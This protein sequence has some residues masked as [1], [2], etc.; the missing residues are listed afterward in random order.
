MLIKCCEALIDHLYFIFKAVCKF[1]MYHPRWLESIIIILH[2]I[3]KTSYNV[4]KSYH[5]IGLI[6]TIPKLFLTL[7]SKHISFL[8]EKH[9]LLLLSQFG[10][11]PGRNMADVMLLVT[12]KIKEAWRKGKV[13]AMLFLDIQG[14]FPNILKDQ[15]IHNMHM[16]QVPNCFINI[17]TTSLTGCT[18]WLKFDDFLLEVL[19]LNNSTTQGDPSSMLYYS[20]YNALLIEV[21]SSEDELSPGFVDDSMMLAIGNTLTQCHAKLKEMMER[22]G[23]G[24]KW[25]FLHNSP[26][27]LS[28]TVLI[29]F[30][31]PY[32]DSI[33]GSLSLD[34][35]NPDRSTSKSLMALV[36]SY[37][38]LGVIFDPKLHWSLQHTKVL[39]VTSFWV[40]RIW[41]LS[42]SASGISTSGTKQLYNTVAIP[43]ITYGA[44]VWFMPLHQPAG[45]KNMR[46]SVSI[47]TKLRSVQWKVAKAITGGLSTTVGDILDV[48]SFIPPIDLLF[49]KLLFHAAL[50]LCSLPKSHPLN[51]ITRATVWHKAKQHCSPLYNL[52]QL[53]Q[54]NPKEVEVISPVRRSPGYTLLISVPQLY[55]YIF[56]ILFE[57]S[58]IFNQFRLNLLY[59]RRNTTL[60]IKFGCTA[61]ITSLPWGCLMLAMSSE[62]VMAG[63]IINTVSG[64]HTL[65]RF[66]LISEMH[67]TNQHV[68]HHP[69]T[70]L[71]QAE[72]VTFTTM[73]H[74]IISPTPL[75]KN[76][77]IYGSTHSPLVHSSF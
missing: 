47:M 55:T 15:L 24:F 64:R 9:N 23:G 8:A 6:N 77:T 34:R 4:A 69:P 40:S 14:A 74:F 29:N 60:S 58:G 16:R 66:C 2:N 67:W 26:F 52:I 30:L 48:H 32:R 62:H 51:H 46:R 21:A 45:A 49:N 72:H 7:C 5:S 10:G 35:P 75:I 31:R 53:T 33:P 25:S 68:T 63:T 41:L 61:F 3:S 42:K 11:R 12:H 39:T 22:L 65:L 59:F 44:E 19:Q 1:N 13:T 27:E 18:T 54:V 73:D 20:F 17:V 38:Y 56:A 57:I 43:R 36:T 28:K 71:K 70:A 37:K 76:I 50:R